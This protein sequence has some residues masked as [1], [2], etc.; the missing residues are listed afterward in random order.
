MGEAFKRL[1][2]W[3][4]F[5]R[6]GP[7]RPAISP[8]VEASARAKPTEIVGAAYLDGYQDHYRQF[9]DRFLSYVRGNPDAAYWGKMPFESMAKVCGGWSRTEYSRVPRQD[10]IRWWIVRDGGL[11]E[12]LPS[13]LAPTLR[14]VA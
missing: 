10:E 9:Q 2:A 1:A 8:H 7:Q 12:D 4:F 3:L 11:I 14:E 13:G 5:W 6:K